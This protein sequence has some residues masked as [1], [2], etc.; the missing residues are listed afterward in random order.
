[1]SS[2]RQGPASRRRPLAARS[3]ED[4]NTRWLGACA[5]TRV[6]LAIRC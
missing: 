3:I 6:C 2:G 5:L 1:M 4:L